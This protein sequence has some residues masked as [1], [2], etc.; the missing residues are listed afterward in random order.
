MTH[1]LL[2]I[3]LFLSFTQ[4]ALTDILSSPARYTCLKG[5]MVANGNIAFVLAV[6]PANLLSQSESSY[7]EMATS[8]RQCQ[9]YSEHQSA[10]RATYFGETL[11][12]SHFTGGA[13]YSSNITMI[14][15][16]CSSPNAVPDKVTVDYYLQLGVAI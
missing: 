4:F 7:A 14:P 2:S 10:E 6:N 13:C 9:S 5:G 15:I 3:V 11:S 1:A 8:A 16:N 12:S